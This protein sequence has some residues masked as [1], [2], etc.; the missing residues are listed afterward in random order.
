MR[1]I[2]P[3]VFLLVLLCG[4]KN[5]ELPPAEIPTEPIVEP[6][7]PGT[8]IP[9]SEIEKQTIGAVRQY[10]LGEKIAW[11][12]PFGED[13]LLAS[14]GD[15]TALTVLSGERGVVTA[16]AQLTLKL[17][18]EDVWQVTSQGFA[19]Y[20]ETERKVYYL[21]TDLDAV[22]A[23]QLPETM[24][25][26]P[27]ISPDGTQVFYCE[28]NNICAMDAEKKVSR[29]VRTIVCLQNELEDCYWGG[30]IICCNVQGED[31]TWYRLYIA[32]ETGET[33]YME[34]HV[35]QLYT[36]DERYFA[37][38]A[39]GTV[40]QYLIGTE[41]QKIRLNA[42]GQLYVSDALR[43]VVGM[44][45]GENGMTVS[46]YALMS[47]MKKAELFLPTQLNCQAMAEDGKN[48]W[49]L[50][51][52]G[53]VLRWDLAA[54]AVSD[55]TVYTG[56]IYTA[57]NPNTAGLE[58]CTQ[59]AAELTNTYGVDVRVWQQ[60]LVDGENIAVTPEYQTDSIHS[61]LTAL[62]IELRKFPTNFLK[63]TAVN[64]IRICIVREVNGEQSS[65]H[66]WLNGDPVILISAGDDVAKAF[67]RA[68]SYILDAH[69]LGNTS[70]AD[71]WASLNPE[72][73]SYGSDT[74]DNAYLIGQTRAFAD[75]N[76]TKSVTED[77]ASIFYY[78]FQS[79][80]EEI[81]QSPIMQEKLKVYGKAIRDAWDLRHVSLDYLW[82]QYLNE[83]IAYS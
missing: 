19:Y 58:A 83:S 15:N 12:T 49:L 60:A 37:V 68:Y 38:C 54:S 78:A 43:G 40:T 11:I 1:R 23:V 57:E 16:T 75:A 67:I 62:E 39:D 61:A 17:T 13:V 41:E 5:S 47:C 10:D 82:E 30:K 76:A 73:F 80:N 65:T 74:V 8:Y 64:M 18:K 25:G 56:P 81:F 21:N 27:V 50:T 29:P 35:Q 46:Y 33:V 72:G 66:C 44:A 71:D 63:K 45:A 77:R 22:R 28:G 48:V 42:P 9:G 51:D 3:L 24:T 53:V 32:A 2:L 59:R 14:A 55:N 7:E 26:D 69:V 20:Q 70:K 6:T 34:K 36:T 79:G 31:E 4:C 52:E